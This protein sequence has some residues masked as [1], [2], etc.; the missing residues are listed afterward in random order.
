MTIAISYYIYRKKRTQWQADE[1]EKG[2]EALHSIIAHFKSLHLDPETT[3]EE[4]NQR[5]TT[6]YYEK[7]RAAHLNVLV[8][9]VGSYSLLQKLRRKE[10]ENILRYYR[11]GT[12]SHRTVVTMC[13]STTASLLKDARERI[14]EPLNYSTDPSTAGVWI[15][16]LNMIPEQNFHV[17]VAIPWWWHTMRE[18]NDQLSKDLA[19]RFKQTLLLKFHHPFQVRLG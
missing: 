13:D 7:A 8:R 14:L 5:R 10:M 4:A 19:A 12:K 16:E 15:P 3:V 18:G 2:H 11:E 17:T 1:E 9:G 6:T